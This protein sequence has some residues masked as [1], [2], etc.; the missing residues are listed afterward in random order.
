MKE[1]FRSDDVKRILESCFS[2]FYL[3]FFVLIDFFFSRKKAKGETFDG[4]FIFYPQAVRGKSDKRGEKR[5]QNESFSIRREPFV[6]RSSV[7]QFNA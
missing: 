3:F 4:K 2:V 6:K 5:G 7:R 1:N